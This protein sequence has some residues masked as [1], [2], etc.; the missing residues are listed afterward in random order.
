MG[1]TGRELKKKIHAWFKVHN[2]TT[3]LEP[4]PPNTAKTSESIMNDLPSEVT[5]GATVEE[6]ASSALEGKVCIQEDS[7]SNLAFSTSEVRSIQTS[8]FDARVHAI[9][10]R[11]NRNAFI[12]RQK[13]RRDALM[14]ATPHG[15]RDQP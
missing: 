10:I 2:V 11:L 7:S 12:R 8:W 13:I 3:E 14:S 9:I 1:F 5:S 15:P 4:S 6:V